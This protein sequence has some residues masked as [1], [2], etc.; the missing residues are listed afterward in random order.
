MCAWGLD[1]KLFKEQVIAGNWIL[2]V[3]EEEILIR[4][5][6]VLWSAWYVMGSY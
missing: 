1:I 6:N 3:D 4:W 2:I 5:E